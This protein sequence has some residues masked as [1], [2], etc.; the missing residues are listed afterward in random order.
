MISSDSGQ[1][2]ASLE[3]WGREKPGSIQEWI[4]LMTFKIISA[5][6]TSCSTGQRTEIV[7]GCWV[8]G[9]VTQPKELLSD[10]T[11]LYVCE[12]GHLLNN[13]LCPYWSKAALWGYP[14]NEVSNSVVYAPIIHSSTHRHHHW[15]GHTFMLSPEF[16]TQLSRHSLPKD[17]LPRKMQPAC[18]A[19]IR[20]WVGIWHNAYCQS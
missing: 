8:C 17:E 20:P 11:A 6:R 16:Y 9:V 5:P 15:P 18:L 10:Y 19:Y 12:Y 4:S 3:L 7:F 1:A 2:P 14:G 13:G